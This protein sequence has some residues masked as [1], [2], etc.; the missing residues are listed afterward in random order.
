MNF[1]PQ[2][3][4]G[5]NVWGLDLGLSRDTW[6]SSVTQDQSVHYSYELRP[7]S[8]SVQTRTRGGPGPD[9]DQDAL[10]PEPTPSGLQPDKQQRAHG[11]TDRVS[12]HP[13]LK[14]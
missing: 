14:K 4:L 7:E 10:P 12:L 9:Q 8:E 1:R 5:V 11:L 2:T 3:N 6:I 13:G